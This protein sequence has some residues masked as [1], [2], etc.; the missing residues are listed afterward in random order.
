[1]ELSFTQVGDDLSIKADGIYITLLDIDFDVF[2]A[3]DVIN[4]L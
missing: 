3:A 4:Y 1:M 2:L